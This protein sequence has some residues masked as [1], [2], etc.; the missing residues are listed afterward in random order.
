MANGSSKSLGILLSRGPGSAE[1]ELI[2]GLARASVG[3]S[4]RVFLFLM[5]EGADLLGTP[6][7]RELRDF[8]VR[9][10]VCTQS[11][12]ARDLPLDLEF[13][14]YSSQ[15]QLGRLVA[16]ADRFVSFA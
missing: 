5:A 7:A 1:I 15:F 10:S 4:V 2:R 14:D 11:A 6:V 9:I 16:S 8:G 12:K 3:R 13:V